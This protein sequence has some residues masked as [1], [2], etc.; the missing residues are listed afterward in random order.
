MR[1]LHRLTLVVLLGAAAGPAAA[2]CIRTSSIRGYEPLDKNL[3]QD[4]L[5]QY[6]MAEIEQ[7]EQLL[8]RDLSIWYNA[9]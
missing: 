2:D 7:L 3:R 5:T 4:L 8:G 9:S 1:A 6:Y